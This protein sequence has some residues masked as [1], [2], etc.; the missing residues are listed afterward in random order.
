M[1]YIKLDK[2]NLFFNLDVFSSRLGGAERI[3]AVL[4]D[5]GYGHGLLEMGQMCREYGLKRCI[6]KNN[7]EAL[8]LK[9]YFD[10]SVVLYHLGEFLDESNISYGV[11]SERDIALCNKN[12]KVHIKIDTG[13]H[14]NGIPKDEVEKIME[15]A[16]DK[17]IEIKGVFTHYKGADD[18][19]ATFFIQR[20]EFEEVKKIATDFCNKRGVQIPKFHSCNSAAALRLSSFEEDFARIGIG[21][22]GYV[23]RD[24]VFG[25]VN[26]KPVMSLFAQRISTL[27]LKK[28]DRVG[29]GGVSEL[30]RDEVVSTYDIG[31]GDGFFRL[32][33]ESQEFFTVNGCKILPRVSMDCVSIASAEDE[34]E[35]FN[36][37]RGLARMFDTITYDVLVKLNP[38]IKRVVKG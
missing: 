3:A 28:G 8:A 26:L 31:Y 16:L 13:M 6:V 24:S 17:K 30:E 11:Y 2:E 23:D 12:Q 18:L 15:L 25:E 10:E 4:K 22:Y 37:V 35:I 19:D 27:N 14:R 5:N 34:I 33:K 36:D 21:M 9:N 29:Y 1:S 20:M 32:S 7:K 38:N